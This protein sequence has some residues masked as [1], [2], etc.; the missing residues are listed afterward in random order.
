MATQMIGVEPKMLAHTIDSAWLS[1]TFA[2]YRVDKSYDAL[3][4]SK[5]NDAHYMIY[6][7]SPAA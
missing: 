5:E 6:Q 7:L 1:A 2:H 3:D 4:F